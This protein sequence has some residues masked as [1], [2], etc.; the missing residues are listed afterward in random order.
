MKAK[1]Q[2]GRIILSLTPKESVSAMDALN[3]AIEDLAD[4]AR[5][6]RFAKEYEVGNRYERIWRQLDKLLHCLDKGYNRESKK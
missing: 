5:A 1:S 6:A 4:D 2:K 3:S